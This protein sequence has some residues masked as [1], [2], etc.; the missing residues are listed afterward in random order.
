MIVN[1]IFHSIDGE[2]LRTGELVTFIR[3]AGCNVR[4][5]YCD[6]AYALRI[7][8]GIEMTIQGILDEVGKYDCE[9]ITL[10]GGEPLIH[11]DVGRLIDVLI[12]HGYK[13]NIETNGAV[14]IKPYIDK[15]VLITMDYKLP[16]SGVEDKMILE[17]LDLLREGDVLKFVVSNYEDMKRMKWIVDNHDV[18]SFIYISPVFGT[19]NPADIVDFMKQVKIKKAR[20]QLQ[21][22]K[23]I[24][25]PDTRGV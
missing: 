19:M 23:L 11:K 12:E 15:D 2:G 17:N 1:E 16:S 22:H 6:T 9:N 7:N 8:Q 24:W 13:V 18:K 3:L 14:K 21:L 5:V 4:C 25:N 20:V 10:T